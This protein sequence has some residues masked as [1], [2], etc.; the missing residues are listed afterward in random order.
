MIKSTFKQ[1]LPCERLVSVTNMKLVYARVA[2]LLVVMYGLGLVP[3]VGSVHTEKEVNFIRG[4]STEDITGTVKDIDD[5]FMPPKLMR[6]N[7]LMRANI[8]QTP[9]KHE[10]TVILDEDTADAEGKMKELLDDISEGTDHVAEILGGSWNIDDSFKDQNVKMT[11]DQA[12]TMS[13]MDSVKHIEQSIIFDDD[14][15]SLPMDDHSVDQYD[16]SRNTLHRC[17]HCSDMCEILPWGLNRIDQR[18]LPLDSSCHCQYSYDYDGS[19]VTVYIVTEFGG[20]EVT[21]EEFVGRVMKTPYTCGDQDSGTVLAGA[22][23]GTRFGVAKNVTMADVSPCAR[24]SRELLVDVFNWIESDAKEKR[25]VVLLEHG[26][27]FD[28]FD[29]TLLTRAVSS[30]VDSGV[31]VVIGV[32]VDRPYTGPSGPQGCNHFPQNSPEVITV[33]S[34][35]REDLSVSGDHDC[36]DIFAPGVKTMTAYIF[37]S[38]PINEY[39][40]DQLSDPALAAAYVAGAVALILQQNPNM[41]PPQIK[42]ELLLRSTKD[43]VRGLGQGVSNRFLYTKDAYKPCR[44]TKRNK[45]VKAIGC[46]AGEF[47]ALPCGC[48]TDHIDS[49]VNGECVPTTGDCPTTGEPVCGCNG[50]QYNNV[51]Q[52]NHDRRNVRF[53]G[54]CPITRQCPVQHTEKGFS[55]MVKEG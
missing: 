9:I 29:E 34:T 19:G 5:K 11:H 3:L 47:C 51:C 48:A 24:W 28:S 8:G 55:R 18:Y 1:V 30:L 7:K 27:L 49:G 2:A 26:V 15:E 38:R 41:T 32:S 54:Q 53:M 25:A 42:E 36:I 16:L 13:V 37:P 46:E 20:I 12:R 40:C 45:G 43:I 10:Y 21:H 14:L 4:T 17:G 22:V 33:G 31:V 23:G 6:V 52:A 50:K 35:D 39:Q 44:I